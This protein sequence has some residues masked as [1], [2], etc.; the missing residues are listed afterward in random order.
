MFS[1]RC[2][3][4]IHVTAVDEELIDH[5][6]HYKTISASQICMAYRRPD[7]ETLESAIFDVLIRNQTIKSQNEFTTLVLK[8]LN[9]GETEYKLSGERLRRFAILKDMVSVDIEYR[10]SRPSALPDIC[11]V[12][13]SNLESVKNS[14]LSGEI[15]EIKRKCPCCSYSAYPRH[16]IPSKYTFNRRTRG[17][18]L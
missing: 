6:E 9:S 10:T 15:I 1:K 11:P 14:T 13:K 7:D 17:I 2:Q 18:S 16:F 5:T 3:N 4:L 12:C 8:E